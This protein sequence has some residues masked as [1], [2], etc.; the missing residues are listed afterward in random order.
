MV[1][2]CIWLRATQ[3]RWE[4]FCC[5]DIS[6]NLLLDAFAGA[7]EGTILK[8]I[9]GLSNIYENKFDSLI[10]TGS[11]LIPD[12]DYSYYYETI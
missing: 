7:T 8:N 3:W 10:P 6:I 9:L 4:W 12:C 5:T 1:Q 11:P 2:L